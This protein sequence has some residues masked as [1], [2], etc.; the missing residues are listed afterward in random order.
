LEALRKR[1]HYAVYYNA[2]QAA[3]KDYMLTL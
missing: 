2:V 1:D 3:V